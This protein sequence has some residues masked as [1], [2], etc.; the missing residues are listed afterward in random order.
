MMLK[1]GMLMALCYDSSRYTRDIDF[2]Q[3][4]KYQQGDEDRLIDELKLALLETVEEMDY[5]LD[6]RFQSKALKPSSKNNPT[7]PTLNVKIGYAY[8]HDQTNHRRLIRGEALK[9]VEIDFSFNEATKSAEE[10]SISEGRTLLRYGLIDL[11]AEK[12]RALLQ[13]Q[14]RNRYRRQDV[15]DLYYLIRRVSSELD[16]IRPEI[17]CALSE[18]AL[19]KSLEISKNSMRDEDIR[20]RT[21]HEY[22]QL[23]QEV[24]AGELPDFDI[25]YEAV[26]RFYE[27]MPWS[28]EETCK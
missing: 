18:S 7:F 2:S 12:F 22:N 16:G 25:A 15:Y 9:V 21:K 1:G 13:Q 26:M 17:L 14:V 4:Q 28:N 11:V 24:S 19:S 3:A 5:G 6:C 10:F 23:E 8:K 27:S 20:L